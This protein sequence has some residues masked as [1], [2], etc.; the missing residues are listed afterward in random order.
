MSKDTFYKVLTRKRFKVPKVAH[1]ATNKI[2]DCY[3]HCYRVKKV[4]KWRKLL[5]QTSWVS[6]NKMKDCYQHCYRVNNVTKCRKL[7]SQK[8]C[9][10]QQHWAGREAHPS[11]AQ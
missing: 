4:T 3:Q 7:D 8:D 10:Q 2:K 11:H 5:T 6:T 1:C 9:Y